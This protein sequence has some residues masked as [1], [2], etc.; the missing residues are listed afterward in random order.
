MK[1]LNLNLAL[2]AIEILSLNED[3]SNMAT[4]NFAYSEARADGKAKQWNRILLEDIFITGRAV[5]ALTDISKTEIEMN[6]VYISTN[7]SKEAKENPFCLMLKHRVDSEG[8]SQPH[9]YLKCV[10]ENGSYLLDS[11]MPDGRKAVRRVW[12]L[13]KPAYKFVR[14]VNMYDKQKEYHDLQMNKNAEAKAEA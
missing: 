2:I 5:K 12:R 7:I 8:N 10:E 14:Y 4:I 6:T 9:Y 13:N 3:N 1:T 11:T